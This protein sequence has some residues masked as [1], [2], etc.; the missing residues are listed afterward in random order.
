MDFNVSIA[1]LK[2][3][4]VG[5]KERLSNHVCK[6][7]QSKINLSMFLK[8]GWRISSV[9]IKGESPEVSYGVRSLLKDDGK[10]VNYGY[11]LLY[12]SS[13]GKLYKF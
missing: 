1:H 12:L 4:C 5:E 8:G 13:A 9:C 11:C 6:Y 2:F 7:L 3:L 10:S